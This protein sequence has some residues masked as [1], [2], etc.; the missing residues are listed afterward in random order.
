MD[1]PRGQVTVEW[2]VNIMAALGCPFTF[3]VRLL[4]GRGLQLAGATGVPQFSQVFT[5][6][7]NDT[8]GRLDAVTIEAWSPDGWAL[9]PPAY[10]RFRG[11]GGPDQSGDSQ[12]NGT[13]G[14]SLPAENATGL[15]GSPGLNSNGTQGPN[16]TLWLPQLNGTQDLPPGVSSAQQALPG[17]VDNTIKPGLAPVWQQPLRPAAG[18]SAPLANSWRSADASSPYTSMYPRLSL[19]PSDKLVFF[20]PVEGA[21]PGGAAD[22]TELRIRRHSSRRKRVV[23]TGGSIHK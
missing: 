22:G 8:I 1:V 14:L 17:A 20:I 13:Q 2:D 15:V 16:G 12:P 23:N 9:C 10:S 3:S 5:G 7:D 4:D 21:G 18:P 19:Q 6:L 11:P